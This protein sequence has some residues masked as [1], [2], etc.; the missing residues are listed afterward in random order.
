MVRYLTGEAGGV[1][2]EHYIGLIATS[3]HNRRKSHREQN[4][5][6]Q[7]SNAMVKHYDKCHGGIVQKYTAKLVQTERSL[8]YLS[9]REAILIEGQLHGTSLN[10]RH[11]RGKGTGV[12]RINP[13]RAGVT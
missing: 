1:R 12:I 2:S 4:L 8:L 9:L 7:K 3:L 13:T 10:D 6:G 11:E 5:V